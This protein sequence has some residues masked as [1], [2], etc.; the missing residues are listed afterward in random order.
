VIYEEYNILNRL[1][2]ISH[3]ISDTLQ[4]S[5]LYNGDFDAFWV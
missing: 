5:L 2:Q 4:P 1:A 3:R